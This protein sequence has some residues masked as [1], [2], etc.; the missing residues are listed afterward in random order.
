MWWDV[1]VVGD[2]LLDAQ[3]KIICPV[4]ILSGY[5]SEGG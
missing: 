4:A 2:E 5:T 1:Y 3:H